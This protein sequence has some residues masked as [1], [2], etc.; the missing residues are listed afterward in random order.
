MMARPKVAEFLLE[1]GADPNVRDRDVGRTPLH[2]AAEHGHEGTVLSL[3]RHGADP[4]A[5][6][7]RKGNTPAHLAA[8]EGRPAQVNGTFVNF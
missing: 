3:L 1:A 7:W 5:T 8:M 6:E 2:D 4:R